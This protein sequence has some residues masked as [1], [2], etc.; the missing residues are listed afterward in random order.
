MPLNVYV[1][2][3]SKSDAPRAARV[4]ERLRAAGVH[5]TYD[6]TL[7]VLSGADHRDPD[8]ARAEIDAVR[9]AEVVLF[10]VPLDG[11]TGAGFEV[12]VAYA[13]GRIILCSG[14]HVRGFHFGSLLLELETDDEAV[15]MLA[16]WAA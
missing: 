5:V 6:W 1:A 9:A 16:R 8:V 12:G 15:E 13:T 10:L 14:P 7:A 3:G 2:A 11:S 4:I